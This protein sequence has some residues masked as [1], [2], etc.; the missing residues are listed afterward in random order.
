MENNDKK[1]K[2]KIVIKIVLLIVLLA[3]LLTTIF[4]GVEKFNVH[5]FNKKNIGETGNG[6]MNTIEGEEDIEEGEYYKGKVQVGKNVYDIKIDLGKLHAIRKYNELGKILFRV[7]NEDEY[8]FFIS[9][10][11][12]DTEEEYDN[13]K[14]IAEFLRNKV[15]SYNNWQYYKNGDD[16]ICFYELDNITDEQVMCAMKIE[17]EFVKEGFEGE[18]DDFIQQLIDNVDIQYQYESDAEDGDKS[19][20]FDYYNY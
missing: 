13:I 5:I 9:F 12:F 2:K 8:S 10:N 1:E 14:V 6:D 15:K 20:E 17:E 7:T 3:I 4:Y 11:V 18:V 16:Y 19:I